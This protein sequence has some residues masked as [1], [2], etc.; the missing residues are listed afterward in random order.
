MNFIQKLSPFYIPPDSAQTGG[1]MILRERILQAMLLSL[2]VLGIPIVIEAS[3]KNLFEPLASFPTLYIYAAIYIITL[4]ATLARQ[5]PYNLRAGLLTFLLL[6]LS[7][8]ELFESGLLGEVRMFLLAYIALTAVLFNA[9]ALIVAMILSLVIIAGAGIYGTNTP[10][11]PIATLANLHQGTDW[12]TSALVFVALS[13]IIAG[14]IA[15]II[16][17]LNSNLKKQAELTQSLEND[18]DMLEDRINER[19]R[20]MARRM[21]QLRT[22]AEI[23]RTISA[24]SDAQDLFQQ[25]ADLIK[26]RFDLYYTGVFLLDSTRQNALLQA[27]TGEPGKRMLSQGHHLAVGGS[28]MIGWSIAN[29]KPRI[30]L[31]VGTEAVRFNNPNLPLTRSELAL[32]IIAHDHVLGAMTIQSEKPNA[33]DENDIS[34]LEGIA[35]SLAIAL[36]NDRLYSETRQRLD[37]IRTLNRE[38]LQ[39]A[40]AE[41]IDIYGELSYKYEASTIVEGRK[42][43]NE[44]QVPLLLRDEVIGEITLEMDQSSLSE[45]QKTFVENVTTQTA[46]ALENARLLHETE[47]RA[48]QEQKLNELATRFSRALNIEE[49]LRAAAQELG[50][51]PAV[52]EVSVQINPMAAPIKPNTGQP[53]FLNSGNGKERAR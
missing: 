48:I 14:A 44:I 22:S 49:I 28:S 11:P 51:L 37:E 46:I 32:P 15:M 8:S 17:G 9:G 39:R 4:V 7:V 33:F 47:R 23:S 16:D 41:T 30:A 19:T 21:V 3:G 40:W 29:R 43:G 45:D 36:E 18:R 34:I 25:I 10:N 27:G 42:P 52:A 31:D 1:L 26:E 53:G 12:I 13:I 5:A 38:Y 50:Q 6:V 20:S 35:D 24:L 2:C